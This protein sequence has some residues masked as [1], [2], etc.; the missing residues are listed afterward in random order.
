MK[1]LFKLKKKKNIFEIQIL[2]YNIYKVNIFIA[3]NNFSHNLGYIVIK[4]DIDSLYIV[5]YVNRIKTFIK[6]Y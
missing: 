6:L 4:K 1:Q 2:Y 3:K 5:N